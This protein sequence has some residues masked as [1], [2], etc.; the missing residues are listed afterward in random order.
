[1]SASKKIKFLYNE[2]GKKTDVVIPMSQYE[3]MMEELEDLEDLRAI[4]ESKLCKEKAIPFEEMKK[5]HLK[6]NV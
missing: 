3:Q 1:M 2:Q 6:K 4:E 5:R